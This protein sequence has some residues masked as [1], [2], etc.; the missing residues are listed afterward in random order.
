[1]SGVRS[2]TFAAAACAA[3]AGMAGGCASSTPLRYYTLSTSQPAARLSAPAGMVP[4]RLD[5]VTI[6]TELDRS[7]LVR[8][9]DSTRLQIMEEDRWAAPLDDMIHR[10]LSQDLAERLPPGTVAD[11]NEPALGEK[12]QSLA[13][14]VIELYGD[15]G[16][17]VSLRAAWVLKRPDSASTRGSEQIRIPPGSCAGAASLPAAMSEALARL[18]DR[19]AGVVAQGAD[20]H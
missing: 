15:A 1:M 2:L 7:Q 4:M 13:V 19:L 10:V 14:D 5:R 12:R 20:A 8:R 6:P 17:A 3:F 11:P 18:S 9:L 16:C